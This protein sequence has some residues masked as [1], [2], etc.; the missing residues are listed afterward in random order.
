MSRK[1]KFHD[2]DSLY[3]VSFATVYWID[4][5][6]RDQYFDEIIKSLDYCRKNKGMEIYGWCIMPSHVHLIFRAQKS[7]PELLLGKFKEHTSK[8]MAKIIEDN[9]LESRREWV[10]W[11]M[12]RAGLKSSNVK[13]RQ[14]WQ[15]HNKPIVL[16]SP[17]VIAQKLNYIH[18]NP[19]VSGFVL[20]PWHWKYSSAFDYCGGKGVLEMDFI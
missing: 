16:W 1:Y 8:Q 15:H 20:E 17:K 18:Q 4:I 7:N 13:H 19:V 9:M 5:F 10:L 14:F 2:K 11:F 12:E 3:F 6:V